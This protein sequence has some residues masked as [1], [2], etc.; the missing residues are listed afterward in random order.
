MLQKKMTIIGVLLPFILLA[1]NSPIFEKYKEKHP[2]DHSVKL[3]EERTVDIFLKNGE[4]FVTQEETEEMLIFYNTIR[5]KIYDTICSDKNL[6]K[7][8]KKRMIRF[9]DKFYETLHKKKKWD[10]KFINPNP[11]ISPNNKKK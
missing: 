10:E 3:L 5:D 4:L 8:S 2:N 9:I 11:L 7:K 6:T 1:Q